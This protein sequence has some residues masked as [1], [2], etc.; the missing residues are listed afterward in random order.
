MAKPFV[1]L[2]HSARVPHAETEN[3]DS[4][5]K[6]TISGRYHGDLE[7]NAKAPIKPSV[8]KFESCFSKLFNLY[9]IPP[10]STH[11]FPERKSSSVDS[12][13]KEICH[14]KPIRINHTTAQER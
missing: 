3:S 11:R 12:L 10:T 5:A 1:C 13:K 7:Y 4:K 9:A 2:P 6:K 14:F 8:L